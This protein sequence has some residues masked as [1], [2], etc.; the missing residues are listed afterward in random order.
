MEFLYISTRAT[1][2][3]MNTEN[4]EQTTSIA[5]N[6]R[7]PVDYLTPNL[8]IQVDFLMC[9]PVGMSCWGPQTVV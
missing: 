6:S 2:Y 8:Q 1:I 9:K 3:F 4:Y 7:H 5:H